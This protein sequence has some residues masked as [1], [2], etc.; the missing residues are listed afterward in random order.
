MI[1]ESHFWKDDLLKQA[2]ELR[3]RKTQTRWPESSFAK[4]ERVLMLGFYSVRK[5]HESNKLSTSTMTQA[6]PLVE[7]PTTGKE[8]TLLNWHHFH[9]L[10]DFDE[11][12]TVDR[13][14]LFVCHQFVHSFVFSPVFDDNDRLD[15]VMFASD[16]QRH[17]SLLQISIDQI[18]RLFDEVGNDYPSSATYK[19]NSK[20]GDYDVVTS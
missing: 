14:V 4:L 1:W 12:T 15:G 3:K 16:R 7:Y 5:L 13:D 8:I 10:Y 6:I 11:A 2:I 18:I 20:T 19:L 9:E 17:T